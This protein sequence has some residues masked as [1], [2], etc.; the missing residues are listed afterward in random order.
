M[1]FQSRRDQICDSRAIKFL[2][3]DGLSVAIFLIVT[4]VL[5]FMQRG[6]VL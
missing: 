1:S 3:S 2:D 4:V 5:V 6:G